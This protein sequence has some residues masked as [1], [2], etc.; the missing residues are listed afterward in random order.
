MTIAPDFATN[1]PRV[2]DCE[3]SGALLAA[4][5]ANFVY[6]YTAPSLTAPLFNDPGLASA[7]HAS[8][9]DCAADWG[10]KAVTGHTLYRVQRQGDWDQLYYAGNTVWFYDPGETKIVH[11]DAALVHTESGRQLD[12]RLRTCVPESI[13]TA[14]LTMYSI[15]AARSTSRTRK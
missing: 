12:P 3:G 4:Q 15:P 5:P 7:T 8:G 6:L 14:T 11:T 9:T 1:T 13:S 2:R 10:D